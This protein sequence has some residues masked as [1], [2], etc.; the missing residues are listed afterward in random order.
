[1]LFDVRVGVLAFSCLRVVRGINPDI[2]DSRV[3]IP[4]LPKSRQGWGTLQFL[5]GV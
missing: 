2:W 4:T 3:K 5:C 1:M